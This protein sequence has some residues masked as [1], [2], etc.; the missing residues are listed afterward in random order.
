MPS[1]PRGLAAIEVRHS[2]IHG[3]GV[4]ARQR[5][6]RGT[7]IGPY[8]GRRYSADEVRARNWNHALTY[9]FGLSDGSVIDGAE[10]GNATRFINHSCAPNCA[11]FEIED[12]DGLLS[13][14]IEAAVDIPS[15]GELFLDYG[16]DVGGGDPSQYPCRCGTPACR[17]TMT[18][19]TPAGA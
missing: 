15:G 8:E 1:A 4:F 10:G 7:P 9:V 16:L 12:E 2:D 11:A 6:R 18:A 17:G 13:I 19:V 5:I 3:D 14:V